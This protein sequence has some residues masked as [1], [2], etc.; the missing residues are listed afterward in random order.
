MS[1]L[2]LKPEDRKS[3]TLRI[4]QTCGFER[5]LRAW[6][7]PRARAVLASLVVQEK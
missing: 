6:V 2:N 3:V 4:R 7:L 5:Q 1:D